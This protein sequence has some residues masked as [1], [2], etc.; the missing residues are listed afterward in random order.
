MAYSP[1]HWPRKTELPPS[2]GMS[3]ARPGFI[4]VVPEL[5]FGVPG[6]ARPWDNGEWSPRQPGRR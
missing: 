5:P 6:L 1:A 2:K 3:E 4:P